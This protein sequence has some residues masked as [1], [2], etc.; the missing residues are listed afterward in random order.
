[1]RNKANVNQIINKIKLILKIINFNFKKYIFRQAKRAETL[2]L[3]SPIVCL[4]KAVRI[5]PPMPR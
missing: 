5:T 3:S 2:H 4:V 1:M